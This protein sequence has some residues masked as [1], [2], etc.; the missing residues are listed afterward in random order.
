ME[1]NGIVVDRGPAA[2]GSQHGLRSGIIMKG[3]RLATVG[4][5]QFWGEGIPVHD[6]LSTINPSHISLNASH[7]KLGDIPVS[8]NILSSYKGNSCISI[9]HNDFTAFRGEKS[10]G[11][12]HP[13]ESA[14][15]RELA[16][17]GICTLIELGDLLPEY[18]QTEITAAVAQLTQ[19]GAIA[20]RHA[21]SSHPLLWLPRCRPSRRPVLE[22][23]TSTA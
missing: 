20:H 12:T 1:N 23:M 6:R 8:L 11:P 3:V 15:H 4:Q 19:E 10:M 18:P 7:I 13:L 17:V 22:A 14:I 5:F 2:T 16:R 21:D 9:F